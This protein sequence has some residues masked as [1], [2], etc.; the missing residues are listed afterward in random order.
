MN[1]HCKI[2][3]EEN[4]G[5]WSEGIELPRCVTQGETFQEL[6]EYLKDVL[7]LYLDEPQ[8]SH[9]TFPLSDDSFEK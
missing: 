8:G 7:N 2:H 4:G 1:C 6:P 9:V 3:K 5:Y